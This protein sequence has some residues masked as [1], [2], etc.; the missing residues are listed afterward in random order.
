MK[1]ITL[2][3]PEKIITKDEIFTARNQEPDTRTVE[4][5]GRDIVDYTIEEAKLDENKNIIKKNKP[6]FYET[7]G[8][9]LQWT[10]RK[11][12]TLAFPEYVANYLKKIYPW[13]EEA[14]ALKETKEMEKTERT[15]LIS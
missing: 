14:E 3:N 11:G 7:T 12:E 5:E 9:S 10:I 1:K 4:S 6:P 13:L 8:R 2:H 15:A